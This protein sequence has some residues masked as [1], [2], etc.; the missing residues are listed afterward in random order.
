[1]LRV[2]EQIIEITT[3]LRF[4]VDAIA[5]KDADLA[6][7]IRRSWTSTAQNAAEGQPRASTVSTTPWAAA[8]WS[9]D[10]RRLPRPSARARPYRL[11]LKRD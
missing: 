1:M 6:R 3:K 5:Q 9:Q 2:I 8:V 4:V 11:I 7:Q 10:F